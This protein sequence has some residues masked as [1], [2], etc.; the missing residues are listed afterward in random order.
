MQCVLLA[1]AEADM[2]PTVELL[3]QIGQLATYVFGAF[4]AFVAWRGINAWRSE[5]IG[6]R[7][8]K[9]AEKALELF[10]KARA[11]MDWIRS[12]GA[13]SYELDKIERLAEES[14]ELYN[15]RRGVAVTIQRYR[16]S[17]AFGKIGALRYRFM[18]VFGAQAEEPFRL[19]QR[20]V[21]QVIAT[22]QGLMRVQ[23]E[24]YRSTSSGVEVPEHFTRQLVEL[25][26]RLYGGGATDEISDT[27]NSAISGLESIC[28]PIID[29]PSF[30]ATRRGQLSTAIAWI[31]KRRW[32]RNRPPLKQTDELG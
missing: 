31:W 22:A 25:D 17:E 15:Q 24:V 32:G 20:V 2:H 8:I 1:H 4:A 11:E 13:F 19:M 5:L 3:I 14:E 21:A 29:P 27:L 23:R 6:T 30:L 12:S 28:K 16:G 10:Y 26:Q 9:I 7:R 18:A